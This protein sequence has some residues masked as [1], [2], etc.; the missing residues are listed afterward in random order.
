MGSKYLAARNAVG[1]A[2]V[3][4]NILVVAQCVASPQQS[5]SLDFVGLDV[6]R[7]MLLI[8]CMFILLVLM[9]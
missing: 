6:D 2:G 9:C 3:V 7:L 8:C 5:S 4:D 1:S